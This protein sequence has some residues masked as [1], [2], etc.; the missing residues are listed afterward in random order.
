MSE[1]TYKFIL[2]G[3][4]GVGKGSIFRKLSTGEFYEKDIST[5][6][7]EKKTLNL[8]LNLPNNKGK[9]E[10]KNF[11]IYL[12]DTAGQEK[13][14]A[15]TFNYYKGTDGVLLIYDITDKS[16]FDSTKNW[17]ENIREA[18]GII[19]NKD[20]KYAIILIGNKLDLVVED[21]DRRKVTE[22]E[23]KKMCEEYDMIWGGELNLKCIGFEELNNLFGNYVGEVYKRI[24]NKKESQQTSKTKKLKYV[25][26]KPLLC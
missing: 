20:A 9:I 8:S 12:F 21:P 25:K 10:K 16:S 2:I 24:G 18:L 7:I 13:F 15:I 23:A 4:S 19:K 26:K 1:I 6:G 5:I 3:N 22:D 17:I 11:V 14:R